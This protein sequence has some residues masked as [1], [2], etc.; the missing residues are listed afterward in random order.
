MKLGASPAQVKSRDLYK[1]YDPSSFTWVGRDE[2]LSFFEE[3]MVRGDAK[4][5]TLLTAE[6]SMIDTR[7]AGLYGVPATGLRGYTY[8]KTSMP[9]GQRAGVLTQFSM[10]AALAGEDEGDPILRGKFVRQQLLCEELPP[11]PPDV[12]AVQPK[13]DGVSTMR[14][15]L[16]KHG[17]DPACVGCHR[18]L[19]PVGFAFEHYD[20]IGAFRTMDAG[21]PIDASG[22]IVGHRN[23]RFK[24]A[25]ELARILSDDAQSQTCFLSKLQQYTVGYLQPAGQKPCVAKPMWDK[26]VATGGDLREA[27]LAYVGS[28]DF[29]TR[30]R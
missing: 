2:T 13:R 3:V 21:K 16:A 8:T 4:L 10:L 9:P 7:L 24:N 14:E 19:D 1:S 20:A 18:L 23:G 28:D 30:V 26:F 5:A 12:N 27:L 15:R 29:V 25:I 22:E 17:N 11:P 6:W